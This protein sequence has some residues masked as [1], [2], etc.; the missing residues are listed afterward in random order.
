MTFLK[1]LFS[2]TILAIMTGCVAY[3]GTYA[4]ETGLYVGVYDRETVYRSYSYRP[5]TRGYYYVPDTHELTYGRCD[6]AGYH[7]TYRGIRYYCEHGI[8]FRNSRI[9]HGH[10]IH[11]YNSCDRYFRGH[12]LP[13]GRYYC[14]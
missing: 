3:P 12:L 7:L 1:T 6:L 10:L 11:R 9:T 8:I 13:P 2:I 5:V 14:R 4:Y